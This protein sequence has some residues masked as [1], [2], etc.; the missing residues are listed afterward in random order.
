MSRWRDDE[1]EEPS[2]RPGGGGNSGAPPMRVPDRELG[3]V[4]LDRDREVP[5]PFVDALDLPRGS[6]RE[7]VVVEGG[8]SVRL[9]GD[10]VR[11]LATVGTFRAVPVSDLGDALAADRS[12]LRHLR[13]SGL[14]E[15]HAL[16]RDGETTT[17]D[18][19]V[20]VL[21]SAG[22]SLLDAHARP[23]GSSHQQYHAG[24]VKPQELAHDASLFRVYRAAAADLAAE[25][26]QVTRVILDYE[27]KGD[28]QRYLNRT[29]RP[30]EAT[31]E[32][33]RAAFAAAH[34]LTVG[35]GHL[36]VPDLRLEFEGPDGER[37]VRDV[38]LV[39]EHY[40]RSQLAGKARAGFAMYRASR[41]G[42]GAARGGTPYDPHRI[43]RVLS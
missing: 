28:Y 8:T 27:I 31:V 10:D 18:A 19:S 35:D 14:I 33:D 34:G 22:K 13:D 12:T 32:S 2:G 21:T 4:A 11:V 6:A 23:D 3:T 40:S 43:T 42:G 36:E 29:D 41:P 5:A 1:R 24:L 15:V 17:R 16:S 7:S 37:G 30:D 26:R 25:G 9:N 39:T 38:E 20:A